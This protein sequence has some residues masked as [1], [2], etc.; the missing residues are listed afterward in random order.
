MSMSRG[1][2]GPRNHNQNY[3]NGATSGGGGS[4]NNSRMSRAARQSV[5]PYYRGASRARGGGG[6]GYHRP[7]GA[8]S[9]ENYHNINGLIAGT[10]GT[11]TSGGTFRMKDYV[12]G[13]NQNQPSATFDRHHY[14]Q[15]GHQHGAATPRIQQ[16]CSGPRGNI[17]LSAG[18]ASA[19]TN[20]CAP[21]DTTEQPAFSGGPAS[22]SVEHSRS[23][24]AV[25]QG[26]YNQSPV[27]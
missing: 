14:N 19:G 5:T 3:Q 22:A 12:G 4:M 2:G 15:R 6:K 9:G 7:G 18:F 24:Q 25:G 1:G 10:N 20:P 21:G 26:T 11:T 27:L 8:G 16:H 23:N 17:T 13:N